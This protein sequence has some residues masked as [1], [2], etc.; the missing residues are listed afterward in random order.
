VDKNGTLV[1]D[2]SNTIKITVEGEASLV[3]GEIARLEVQ[4]QKVEAGLGFAY[5][6]SSTTAGRILITAESPGL[7]NG[8]KELVSVAPTGP[9]VPDGIHAKWS[10]DA[11]QFEPA[12][13]AGKAAPQ[14][15][16]DQQQAVPVDQIQTIT[17]S[18]PS[19]T[20]RGTDQ[21]ID[22][23]TD[24]GTGWLADSQTCPQ[25]ITFA[26]KTPQKLSGSQIFWE[27][28]STW[29]VYDLETSADGQTWNKVIDTKT[30]TGSVSTVEPFRQKQNGVRFARITIKD[31]KTGTPSVVIGL[32]EVK[33]Y[34]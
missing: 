16:E 28:D 24:F 34:N 9:G 6:R 2:A 11:N 26:F 1:P 20:G 21:L 29:Y 17:A 8:V 5:L 13:A 19:V 18:C 23:K 14:E 10:N 3:G 30:V 27:K 25:S 22:G 4:Q 32:A 33:F 31:V 15:A 7:A 12:I